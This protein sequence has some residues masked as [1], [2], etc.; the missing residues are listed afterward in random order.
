MSAKYLRILD[1][2]SITAY[3]AL[4]GWI[5]VDLLAASAGH[6]SIFWPVTLTVFVAFLLADLLSGTV[7]FL[8][9]NFGNENTPIFGPALIEP[10]RDHHRDPQGITRHGFLETN[11]NNCLICIPFLAG[12]LLLSPDYGSLPQFLVGLGTVVALLFVFLTNQIHKWAHLNS[13]PMPIRLLQR[14]GIVL[15]SDHHAKHHLPPHL[16]HYC[17]TSGWLNPILDRSGIL[18]WLLRK[19]GKLDRVALDPSS[20]G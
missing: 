5:L 1:A 6:A 12:L 14:T 2:V 8:A 11:G 16:S 13:P 17:I 3:L 9:D 19:S 4:T 18:N 20:N 7:H 10:F 15:S